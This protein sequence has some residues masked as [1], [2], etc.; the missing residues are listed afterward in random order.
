MAFEDMS[1]QELRSLAKKNGIKVPRGTKHE[2]L[3]DILAENLPGAAKYNVVIPNDNLTEYESTHPP[4]PDPAVSERDM[5]FMTKEQ[6]L[7][8]LEDRFGFSYKGSGAV[9][10]TRPDIR[11]KIRLMEIEKAGK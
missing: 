4:K 8:H 1:Y 10:A 3:I 2:G 7:R 6:M 5:D 11:R 9:H